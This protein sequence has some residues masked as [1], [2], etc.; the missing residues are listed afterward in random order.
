MIALKTANNYF[1]LK[2]IYFVTA[3]ATAKFLTG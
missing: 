3:N 1:I 2:A